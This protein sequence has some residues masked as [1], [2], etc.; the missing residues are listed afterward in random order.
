LRR[1]KLS[2]VGNPLGKKLYESLSR[3]ETDGLEFSVENL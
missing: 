3:E 2:I 1:R